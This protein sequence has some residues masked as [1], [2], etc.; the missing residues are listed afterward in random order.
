MII[1]TGAAGFIGSCLV[2][3][4]NEEG[5]G[6]VIA[7][8]DFSNPE[9]NLNLENKN[10]FQQTD[11]F[12]FINKL[13]QFEKIDFVFHIGARTDTSEFDT[14]LLDSLNT[15]YSIKLWN[16]CTE[17]Q[18]PMIYASSAAT[19]GMGELGFEDNHRIIPR[20]KPLNP[21][22]RSKQMFDEFVL[23]Q[24]NTPPFWAGLKFF[25]VFGPNEYHKGRMASM[26]LHGT[27][28]ILK[29]NTIK[30]FRSH[31][32]NYGDGEQVRDFIYVMDVLEVIMY[33][34]RERPESAI[35]NLGTGNAS[36]WNQLAGAIFKALNK[37]VQIEYIDIPKDIRST[38]QYFT[39]AKMGKLINTGY[40]KPF[41]SLENAVKDYVNGYII[42]KKYF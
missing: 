3:R 24:S 9:K 21:Y 28:Q 42:N 33:L 1:V 27:H 37:D 35:Y 29:S 19:Y 7:V 39:E 25:N 8:D 14:T 40:K 6:P 16:Y 15:D 36:S 34:Y 4:L 23:K 31:N 13:K 32:N 11:R 22:G 12:D 18:I 5:I 17:Q 41:T 26:V 2:K 30:L 10:I 38:Y 20:L